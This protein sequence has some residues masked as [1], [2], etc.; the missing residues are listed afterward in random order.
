MKKSIMIKTAALLAVTALMV[1]PAAEADARVFV[2]IGLGVP[3][4]GAYPAY[5]PAYAYPYPYYAPPPAYGYA[6]PPPGYYP[7]QQP[8][9]QYAPQYAPQQYPQ[10][11]APQR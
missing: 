5:Y 10:Q 11:Y 6:A 8:A 3:V 4:Y 1:L 7:P 9:P 2:G